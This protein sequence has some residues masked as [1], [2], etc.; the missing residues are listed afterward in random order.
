MRECRT[1]ADRGA[2]TMRIEYLADHRALVPELARLH[3]S[4]WGH[5]HPDETIED[6]TRRLRGSC[7]RSAV[8][9]V[10]VALAGP[11]LR[12]SAMLIAHDMDSRPELT[13][14]L[15]GVYVLPEHRR[16]GY[17]S[18][19]VDRVVSEAAALGVPELYLYTPDADDFYSR[20]GWSVLEHCEYLGM[21]VVVMSRRTGV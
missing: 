13:P 3:F 6:R 5:L 12:G 15:A 8:P 4:Q 14:W 20:L 10:L 17:G 11:E 18:A 9:T 7:G 19:L 1:A 21:Q 16:R 2:D